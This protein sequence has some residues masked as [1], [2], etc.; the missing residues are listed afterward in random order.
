MI[1][2]FIGFFQQNFIIGLQ[3][4]IKTLFLTIVFF[5]NKGDHGQRR[6]LMEAEPSDN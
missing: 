2:I 3:S 5:V 4:L 1:F 6:E